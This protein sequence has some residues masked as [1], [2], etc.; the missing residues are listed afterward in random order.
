MFQK[1]AQF[2]KFCIVGVTNTS[3]SLIVY[4][5][6]LN[7]DVPYLLASTLAYCAGLLNGYL[8]SSSFV[9]KQKRTAGQAL[10]FISVYISSLLINLLLL[11][12]L[13][14]VFIISE[15]PAQVIVTFFNVFYNFILNKLWT[16]KS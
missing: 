14:D 12:C 6:L 8:L 13:V 3:I 5:F 4:Y 11:F 16:F 10:K 15:F 1:H 2:I 7:A 9:F